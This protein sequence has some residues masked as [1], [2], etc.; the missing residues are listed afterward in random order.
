MVPTGT[1]WRPW[2]VDADGASSPLPTYPEAALPPKGPRSPG[3]AQ[4]G[5]AAGQFLAV[6]VRP[7]SLERGEPE[8]GRP[9]SGPDPARLG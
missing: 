4:A 1:F 9:G 2:H 6:P 3:R 5:D 8:S 7:E